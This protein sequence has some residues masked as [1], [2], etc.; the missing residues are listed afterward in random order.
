M[1]AFSH[2]FIADQ[3]AY[4]SAL[5]WA[6]ARALHSFF[7]QHIITDADRRYLAIDEGD[8]GALLPSLASRV[9]ET[10]PGQLSDEY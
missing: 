5:D 4:R 3:A 6:H 9:I 10:I 7:N 2:D 8:Y 1:T